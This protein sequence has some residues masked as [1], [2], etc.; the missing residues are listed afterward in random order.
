MWLKTTLLAVEKTNDNVLR[1]SLSEATTDDMLHYIS[2]VLPILIQR[3]SWPT[4][5][6]FDNQAFMLVL[7]NAQLWCSI[8]EALCRSSVP[9]VW[10]RTDSAQSLLQDETLTP[11]AC[12]NDIV[13]R[14]L[15][16]CVA[17]GK[18]K[19]TCTKQDCVIHLLK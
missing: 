5:F 1:I 7:R 11:Y 2:Y 10:M 6:K 9:S 15:S 14:C 16:K 13:A 18:A 19:F 4:E 12:I 8:D 3:S 17:R